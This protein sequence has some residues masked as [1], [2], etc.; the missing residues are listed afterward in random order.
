MKERKNER[1]NEIKEG[2]QKEKKN[3]TNKEG[4]QKEPV[5]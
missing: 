1:E 4:R 3:E 2:R 5:I